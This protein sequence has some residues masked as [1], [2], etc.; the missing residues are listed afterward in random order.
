M[1]ASERDAPPSMIA[2]VS[3]IFG[4][5]GPDDDGLGVR[6][7]GRRTGLA[8]S[9]VSRIV[10]ELVEHKFLAQGQELLAKMPGRDPFAV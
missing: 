8:T 6:E 5:F 9:T 4:A 10:R 1:C 3:L 2:R 7:I